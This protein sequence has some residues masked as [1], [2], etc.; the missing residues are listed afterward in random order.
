MLVNSS[1]PYLGTENF[2]KSAC[3]DFKG[4]IPYALGR[5]TK[6][7]NTKNSGAPSYVAELISWSSSACSNFKGYPTRQPGDFWRAIVRVIADVADVDA[8]DAVG[9]TLISMSPGSSWTQL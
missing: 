9:E 7:C 8:V 3:S 2:K 1:G 5:L 6:L 4:F